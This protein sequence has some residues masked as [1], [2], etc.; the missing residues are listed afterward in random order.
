[1]DIKVLRYFLA[2]AREGNI[3]KAA[4]AIHI[5]QPSLSVQL[6]DLERE[7][8]QELLLR[9]KRQIT[10][11]DAGK[12][13]Y[14][15]A[16][17]I[18]A[19]AD[20]A[21]KELQYGDHIAGE[22]SIGSGELAGMQYL[23]QAALRLKQQYP[24]IQYRLFNGDADAITDRLDKG[25]LDFGILLEPVNV[26]KYVRLSLPVNDNW[27]L[28]LPA[29]SRL[30]EKAAITMG[31]LQELPLIMPERN[32]LQREISSWMPR[33]GAELRPMATYNTIQ[34]GILLV[35]QGFGYAIVMENLAAAC[36]QKG[37]CFRPLE[38]AASVQFSLAWKRNK[39]LSKAAEKFL[40]EVQAVM[41]EK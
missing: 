22:L 34:C 26:G 28:L 24:N 30:A 38:Q 33:I 37:L 20:K 6:K 21:E 4:E 41:A 18:V 2:V 31:E 32:D 11:T 3:T 15:R 7:L 23:M 14:Q 12:L 17:E 16:E 36:K 10:L 9:G 19:L 29:N 25:L 13:L 8:G 27:G 35:E 5:S 1:M 40:L 39:L